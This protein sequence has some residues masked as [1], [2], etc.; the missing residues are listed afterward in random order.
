MKP[1]RI[2][3]DYFPND[4]VIGF[5]IRSPTKL[6]MPTTSP[7][8]FVYATLPQKSYQV[9]FIMTSAL[10][11]SVFTVI[12][13][14]QAAFSAYNLYLAS[15]SISNLMGYEEKSKKAAEY[16]NIAE[17]QLHK[18]RTTQASGTIAVF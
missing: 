7:R 4:D 8:Y 6:P 16:S 10:K 11:T 15:T 18:T 13:G 2:L 12:Y 3:H 5:N 9:E 14:A 1:W 17:H